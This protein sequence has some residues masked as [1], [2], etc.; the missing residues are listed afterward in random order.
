MA[1]SKKEIRAIL[2]TLDG[3][4]LLLPGSVVAEVI[5]YSDPRMLNGTPPWLLSE[6]RWSDW[7]VPVISFSMLAGKS[8]GENVTSKSR[9]LVVKSLSDS[10][11]LPYLGFLISGIPHM[12]KIKPGSLSE[13]TQLPDFPSVFS[14]VT[15]DED[16]ALIPD[17]DELCRVVEEAIKDL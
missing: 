6:V 2:A 17:L 1:A 10:A 3:S 5:N 14:E 4:T 12:A 15:V 13:P 9:V 16:K 7:N 8:S 11:N